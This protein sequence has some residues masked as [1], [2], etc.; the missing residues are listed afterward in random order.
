MSRF[1]MTCYYHSCVKKRF[2]LVKKFTKMWVKFSVEILIN[3][4]NIF[5]SPGKSGDIFSKKTT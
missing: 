5:A 3:P 2:Y 1:W 4:G